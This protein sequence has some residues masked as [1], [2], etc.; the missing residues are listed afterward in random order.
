[1]SFWTLSRMAAEGAGWERGQKDT[2]VCVCEGL[3]LQRHILENL[4]QL[5][6]VK[7]L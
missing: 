1:M 4:L 3:G 5:S 6:N 7:M 2:T